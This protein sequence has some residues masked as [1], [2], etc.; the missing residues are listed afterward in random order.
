MAN[1]QW[2]GNKEHAK[3]QAE[4]VWLIG[5]T[6]NSSYRNWTHIVLSILLKSIFLEEGLISGSDPDPYSLSPKAKVEWDHGLNY[7]TVNDGPQS[8]SSGIS[9][10]L[11]KGK[12][13]HDCAKDHNHPQQPQFY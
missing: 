12:Q 6:C 5:F 1:E 11:H 2:K 4:A 8:I 7:R 13:Q 10:E 9:K 3:S